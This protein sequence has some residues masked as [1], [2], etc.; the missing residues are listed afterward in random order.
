[1]LKTK[2]FRVH[3]QHSQRKCTISFTSGAGTISPPRKYS[4]VGVA[5]SFTGTV[6]FTLV[7]FS[8]SREDGS[9]LVTW[10]GCDGAGAGAGDGDCVLVDGFAAG[11]DAGTCAVLD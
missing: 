11:K 8:D 4:A 7:V 5:T 1:M 6:A 3:S 10:G 9:D 2:D